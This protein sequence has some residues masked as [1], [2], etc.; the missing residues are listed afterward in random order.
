MRVVSDK[1][2]VNMLNRQNTHLFNIEANGK[3]VTAMLSR[4]K[5]ILFF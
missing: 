1:R 5:N 3:K 2:Y 4:L